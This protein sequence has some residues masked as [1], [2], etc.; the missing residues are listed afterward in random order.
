MEAGKVVHG[1]DIPEYEDED[2][3]IVNTCE[4]KSVQWRHKGESKTKQEKEIAIR[5]KNMGI[6][7]SSGFS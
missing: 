1:A 5:N 2:A 7:W 4:R 3:I 6:K